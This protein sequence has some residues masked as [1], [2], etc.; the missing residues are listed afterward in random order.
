MTLC[1]QGRDATTPGQVPSTQ[2]AP[3]EA[4]PTEVGGTCT[5][6]APQPPAPA[7]TH[8]GAER[9]ER[10]GVAL[11]QHGRQAAHQLHAGGL[12][13]GVDGRLCAGRAGGPGS[14]GEGNE[15]MWRL[16]KKEWGG[17]QPGVGEWWGCAAGLPGIGK[18]PPADAVTMIAQPGQWASRRPPVMART[19]R[20]RPTSVCVNV[21]WGV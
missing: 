10:D 7:C 2:E 19:A 1:M 3:S 4:K 12:G 15:A 21:C 6:P 14:R 13:G 16:R 17:E 8:L 20:R 18:T 9:C 11:T 5:R